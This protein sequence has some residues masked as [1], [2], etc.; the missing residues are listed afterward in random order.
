MSRKKSKV[1]SAS[2]QNGNQHGLSEQQQ[3]LAAAVINLVMQAS[4]SVTDD[5][6]LFSRDSASACARMPQIDTHANSNT[7]A[8]INRSR[9]TYDH[10]GNFIHE[11]LT[12]V[13]IRVLFFFV[14]LY[15]IISS[16]FHSD[17][18]PSDLNWSPGWRGFISNY[19]HSTNMACNLR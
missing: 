3:T 19:K 1:S 16:C 17:I 18:L 14:L 11:G 15:Y 8:V 10:H 2:T 5:D 7:S 12:S 6:T 9:P 13:F 4:T